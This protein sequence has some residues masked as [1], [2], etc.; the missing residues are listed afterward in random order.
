MPVNSEL[1]RNTNNAFQLTNSRESCMNGGGYGVTMESLAN[2]SNNHQGHSRVTM[3][4]YSNCGGQGGGGSGLGSA[5][6]ALN[7]N[8]QGAASYGFDEQGAA[9]S[10]ELRGSYAAM[11]QHNNKQHCGG[12]KRNSRE[13]N[14]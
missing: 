10:S 6:H 13:K 11:T 14:K 5:S 9:V 7:F 1:L 4:P 3:V 8:H 12:K 2:D